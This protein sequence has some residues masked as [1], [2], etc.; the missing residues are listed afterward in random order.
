MTQGKIRTVQHQ[1]DKTEF[2][3]LREQAGLSIEEAAR[4]TKV[5]VRAAYRHESG[6][7][8]PSE[9]ALDMLAFAEPRFGRQQRQFLGQMFAVQ[10][11]RADF[12][13]AHA[14]FA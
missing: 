11:G 5:S 14:Q 4:I 2:T 3:R 9:L 6:E 12:G 1:P 10:V 7:N 8:S 13:E